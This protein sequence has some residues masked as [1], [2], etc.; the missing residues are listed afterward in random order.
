M[1]L[2]KP[3]RISAYS[4]SD[5]ADRLETVMRALGMEVLAISADGRRIV[6][7]YYADD[8]PE[9]EVKAELEARIGV[10]IKWNR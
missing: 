10:R 9:E 4:D 7:G 6:Y 2:H 8:I 5:S 1:K 3:H